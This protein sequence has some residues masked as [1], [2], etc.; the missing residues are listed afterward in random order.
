MR[1]LLL[2]FII[3]SALEIGVFVWIGGIA[4]PWWVVIGI[5]LTGM[6][7]VTIAK[8]QGME[9]WRQAQ[10]AMLEHR[11]P[12]EQIVDGI[13]IFIGALFLFT[14]GFITDL[15]GFIFV[16]PWTRTAFKR[17]F[18]ERIRQMVQKN[19]IHIRYRR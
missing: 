1:L 13:Y 8:K 14:P 9:T 2:I 12:G 10:Q 11:M 5:I 18:H 4:G 15:V 6:I 19:T 17:L 7:G 16:I 3:L